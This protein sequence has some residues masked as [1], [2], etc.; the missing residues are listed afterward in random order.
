MEL[1]AIKLEPKT[2]LA[3][4]SPELEDRNSPIEGGGLFAKEHISKGELLLDFSTYN[5]RQISRS[6]AD[7]LY[8][9]GFDH[10]LQVDDDAFVI[11][12]LGDEPKAYGH[13]NHSC[14][15][16]CGIQGSYRFVAMRDIDP[17]EEITIDYAMIDSS[18]YRIKCNCGAV[19]CRGVITGEDWNIP[20]LQKRYAGYFSDYLQKKMK[21]NGTTS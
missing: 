18:E 21:S 7:K 9:K 2:R 12:V 20:D 4:L 8:L 17:G 15:P 1:L 6:E 5:D 10:L 11:T 16:N 3:Y 19:R 14:E 13:V